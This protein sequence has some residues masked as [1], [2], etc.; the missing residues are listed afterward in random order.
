MGNKI[1]INP[2]EII[3]ANLFDNLPNFHSDRQINNR[4]VIGINNENSGIKYSDAD[5]NTWFY[6]ILVK[7]V[8]E[9]NYIEFIFNGGTSLIIHTKNELCTDAE[10][11]NEDTNLYFMFESKF[12]KFNG[13]VNPEYKEIQFKACPFN[14]ILTI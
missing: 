4:I 5:G 9:K 14:K 13:Q 11:K 12:M 3:S 8:K 7:S 10:R 6:E 1:S 2:S